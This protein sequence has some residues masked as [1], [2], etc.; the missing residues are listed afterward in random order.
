M[1]SPS[2][3]FLRG[4]SLPQSGYRS[5][6]AVTE[7]D[8]QA[9]QSAGTTADVESDERSLKQPRVCK[10]PG[11][12]KPYYAKGYCSAHYSKFLR[13]HYPT[14]KKSQ[15][16]R[17]SIERVKGKVFAAYGGYICKGCGTT[18]RRVLTIDHIYNDGAEERRQ[19]LNGGTLYRSIV[20]RNFPPRYQILCMNCQ[21]VKRAV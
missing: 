4:P 7:A 6:Y 15:Y 17:T 16:S 18:D 13:Q 1:H 5:V 3:N 19:G 10:L 11:C 9:I 12:G 21:W 20:K 14:Y 2:P 8:A